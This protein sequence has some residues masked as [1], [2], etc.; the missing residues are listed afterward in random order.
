MNRSF[1]MNLL[2]AALVIIFSVFVGAGIGYLFSWGHGLLFPASTIASG[3]L[4]GWGFVG[5]MW[6]LVLIL[7]AGILFVWKRGLLFA[8]I[9]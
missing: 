4:A 2:V 3:V 9:Y 1:A 8:G 7:A 6:F 5:A